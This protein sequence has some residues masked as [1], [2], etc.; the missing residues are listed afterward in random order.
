MNKEDIKEII[1]VTALIWLPI[2]L[3]YLY[4]NGAWYEPNVF[5]LTAELLMLYAYPVF[6]IWRLI[7]YIRRA[8]RS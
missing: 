4:Y 3:L 5:I 1:T 7:S 8:R 2:N 6:G